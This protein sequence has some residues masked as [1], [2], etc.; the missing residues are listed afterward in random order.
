MATDPANKLPGFSR[1]YARQR[2]LPNGIEEAV[3][4]RFLSHHVNR[5]IE[6]RRNWRNGKNW[7][8]NSLKTLADRMPYIPRATLGDILD[9]LA[10]DG[11]IVRAIHNKIKI[12]RTFWYW[13]PKDVRDQAED[14]VIYFN[15]EIAVRFGKICHGVLYE[16]LR[17]ISRNEPWAFWRMSPTHL[18]RVLPFSVATIR[19]A[20]KEMTAEGVLKADQFL[21]SF[22]TITPFQD[23]MVLPNGRVVS[24]FSKE[25]FEAQLVTDDAIDQNVSANTQSVSDVRQSVSD[26]R[27]SVSDEGQ[28]ESDDN[29]L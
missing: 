2:G 27:R 10:A 28:S 1:S 5:A 15:Q 4:V 19:R 9:R 26:D 20:L 29:T 14:D 24:V 22:Y 23:Q 17:Y 25:A 16:H 13:V 8:F 12:D 11:Q 18:S 21:T 3:V 7:Y 6:Q